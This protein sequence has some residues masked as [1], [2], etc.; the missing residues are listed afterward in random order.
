MARKAKQAARGRHNRA[1]LRRINDTLFAN[2][3]AAQPSLT[4]A[5]Q[6]RKQLLAK[7]RAA[8]APPP[9]VVVVDENRQ[10]YLDKKRKQQASKLQSLKAKNEKLARTIQ[11]QS[12]KE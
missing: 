11:N 3:I 8:E 1:R 6:Y 10:K 12:Q 4:K 2:G 9:V 5:D 7:K